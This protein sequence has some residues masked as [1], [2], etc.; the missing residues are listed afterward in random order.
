MSTFYFLS[1][2]QDERKRSSIAG[3]ALLFHLFMATLAAA[4]VFFWPGILVRIF[5]SADLVRYSP[6]IAAV[7]FLWICSYLIES[8]ATANQDVMFSTAFII[9]AQFSKSVAMLT[10]ALW[11]RSIEGLLYAGMIQ[12]FLQTAV[13]LGYM[14]L[15]FPGYW[16]QF[17]IPML[18]LQLAYT[19][20]LGLAG[21]IYTLQNDVHNYFVSNAFGAAAF[22]IYSVGV[23]QL[24]LIGM[25]RESINSVLL[26]RVSYLQ[27]EGRRKEILR[28]SLHVMRKLALVYW[29]LYALMM[30]VANEFVVVLYTARFASSVPLLRLNLTLLPF[31]IIVQDPVLRAFAEH[32]YY[33]LAMRIVLVSILLAVLTTS[34]DRIGLMGA[35]SLVVAISL[36]ERILIILKTT[37][38]LGFGREDAR[39]LATLGRIA[40]IT[41]AAASVGIGVR[42]LMI[43][44]KPLIVLAVTATAF[45]AVYV[46]LL[47]RTGSLQA[48]ERELAHRYWNRALSLLPGR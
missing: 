29:P 39:E 8:I 28:L 5:G 23:A 18:R 11:T 38:V 44:Q 16:R 25:M 31:M 24:P 46:A 40:A 48:D 19:L 33:L 14:R 22:A 42:L 47:L 34:L 41:G 10:A 1:R 13:L 45:T 4:T 2:E 32:R 21:L 15:R 35:V 9:S 43:Q 37:R 7:M 36:A 6:Q 30:I 20:P 17:S 3:N 26:G 12:G 27:Q